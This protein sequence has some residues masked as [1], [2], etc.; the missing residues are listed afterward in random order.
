MTFQLTDE[1]GSFLVHLAREAIILH[2]RSGEKMKPPL[3]TPPALKTRCGVF[4]TLNKVKGGE[5]ELRGC[6]GYPE[7]TAPLVEAT[8]DSALNAAFSDPRFPPLREKELAEVVV[9]VSVLTPLQPVRVKDPREHLNHI[10]VG[11]DGLV[12]ERGWNRG[13]LLPQVPVEW[14]WDVEEFLA[15]GCL[16]AGL[17]PDAWLL[18]GTKIYK[19]QAIIFEEE[20]PGGK[21]RRRTQP[22]DG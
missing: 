9:E 18:S 16:K 22:S 15:H 17:P 14:G 11:V 5:K 21:V 13:L 19:F 1:E 12:V 7:P 2:L 4:V 3:G 8:I 20:E 6:I 10:K